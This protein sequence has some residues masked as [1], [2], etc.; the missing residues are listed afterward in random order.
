ML[1]FGNLS[2]IAAAA[3]AA[4]IGMLAQT[5]HTRNATAYHALGAVGSVQAVSPPEANVHASTYAAE[6]ANINHKG[7]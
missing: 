5:H 1:S 7:F 3:L 6:V 2:F 4:A